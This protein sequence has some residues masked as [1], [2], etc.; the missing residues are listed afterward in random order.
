M[1]IRCGAPHPSQNLDK[2]GTP[3]PLSLPISLR[4]YMLS[5]SLPELFIGA[6]PDGQSDGGLGTALFLMYVLNH[7]LD[8]AHS[9]DRMSSI[10]ARPTHSINCRVN[11]I[12]AR[13]L[14]KL[15]S[16]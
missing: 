1:R 14:D 6:K 8:V 2:T 4:I 9:L 12:E 11:G 16:E 15:L 13:S 10:W 7:S 5:D 3:P